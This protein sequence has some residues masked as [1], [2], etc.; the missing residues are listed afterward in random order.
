MRNCGRTPNLQNF[1]NSW[2]HQCAMASSRDY[3]GSEAFGNTKPGKHGLRRLT[4]RCPDVRQKF[5][6][7]ARAERSII[8]LG[9]AVDDRGAADTRLAMLSTENVGHRKTGNTKL[10]L[11]VRLGAR[12]TGRELS[13][14][15]RCNSARICWNST[16]GHP[17]VVGRGRPTSSV[18]PPQ[19]KGEP[20]SGKLTCAIVPV[21][22]PAWPNI[23]V[24]RGPLP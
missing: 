16:V 17:V 7:Q 2:N 4:R 20:F 13:C 12:A 18:R 5:W 15:L 6:R 23:T 24:R 19:A 8:E 1:T 11:R 9:E 22:A 3:L 21:V 14:R 10:K